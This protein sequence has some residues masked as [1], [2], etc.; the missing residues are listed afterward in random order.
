MTPAENS[1]VLRG[2]YF[3]KKIC[4]GEQPIY[5]SLEV[6]FYGT[7]YSPVLI[8]RQAN[9]DAKG[10]QTPCPYMAM[11][12]VGEILGYYKQLDHQFFLLN[13]K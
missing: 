5:H 10:A 3:T 1:E 8:A 13:V 2:S 4:Q 9:A 11:L 7:K 6:G 12:M